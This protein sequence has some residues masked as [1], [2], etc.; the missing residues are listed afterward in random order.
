MEDSLGNSWRLTFFGSLFSLEGMSV[1]CSNTEV[2]LSLLWLLVY[3]EDFK[4]DGITP[5]VSGVSGIFAVAFVGSSLLDKYFAMIFCRHTSRFPENA[6]QVASSS[7]SGWFEPDHRH[8][9]PRDSAL[10]RDEGSEG[11]GPR[12]I[13]HL[14]PSSEGFMYQ[15]CQ[16]W[17]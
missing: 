6:F 11:S 8:S 12:W 5:T 10:D 17:I 14:E 9:V 7:T 16:E 1:S 13:S 2:E 4:D 3:E 15:G